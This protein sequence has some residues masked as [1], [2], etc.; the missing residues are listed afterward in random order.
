MFKK[1]SAAKVRKVPGPYASNDL[2]AR[3][4][5]LL[6]ENA[7]ARS[8]CTPPDELAKPDGG[9]NWRSNTRRRFALSADRTRLLQLHEPRKTSGRAGFQTRA[10]SIGVRASR[11]VPTD[12]EIADLI[13]T[14]HATHNGVNRVVAE[15]RFAYSIKDLRLRVQTHRDGCKT[16]HEYDH[17][18]TAPTVAIITS[19]PDE[20]HVIDLASVKTPDKHGRRHFLLI[21]DHFTKFLAGYP[22]KHKDIASVVA[23]LRDLYQTGGWTPP[24]DW[25]MDNGSEFCNADLD[26]VREQLWPLGQRHGAVRHPQ[27]Q[28]LI[29]NANG[30]VKRKIS[31]MCSELGHVAGRKTMEWTAPFFRILHKE[32]TSFHSVYGMRFTPYFCKFKRHYMQSDVPALTGEEYDEVHALMKEYQVK[33]AHR[34]NKIVPFPVFT[35]GQEVHVRAAPRQMAGKKALGKWSAR[36]VVHEL[37]YNTHYVVRWLTTGL[38][39]EKPGTLSRRKFFAYSLKV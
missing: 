26:K 1:G 14:A 39:G 29:E 21:R 8:G 7:G 3:M 11:V 19:Y 12:D 10:A 37:A 13:C 20:L 38:S 22:M 2:N 25:L 35:I 6:T 23:I 9:K 30:T 5:F 4:V 16:C 17:V 36:G 27:T 18:D 34:N 28:G 33:R 31:K 24:Q 15:L 32:N